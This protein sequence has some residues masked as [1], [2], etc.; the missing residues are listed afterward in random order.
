[1]VDLR[2]E[3]AGVRLRNPTM[4]ASGFLDET[5]GSMARVYEAGAGAVVTKSIGPKPRE[6]YPNPTIVELDA[7]LLNAVGLPNP[8]VIEYEHEVKKAHAAGAVVIGSVFG[9][10]AEEYAAVAAKMSTY[11]V[12]AIELNLSCPHARGLG[13]E[14]AQDASAVRD[15]TRTV[16][17]VVDVPVFPKL[18]PN[19]QDIATFAMAAEEGGADGIVAINTLKAMAI[20]PE[21][22]M[23][24]LANKYGG[25][26]GPAIRSIGVRAVY[27]I[28]E[29]VHVP[30]IGVGGVGSGRD[31]LEYIMA[32]ASAVQIG[33]AILSR[34]LGVF[35]EVVQEMGVLLEEAGFHSVPEAI[36][37]AHA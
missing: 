25:L 10:D 19:V 11:G 15:F 26:S 3:I 28:C 35:D 34:G 6:G 24:S 31:A 21:L 17:D 7:G 4:L 20:T 18:S 32:G 14:I 27:D 23:P 2:T 30:V 36:G 13:T 29:K 37:V 1:M 16:K 12:K 22:K 33:T 8:G 5:G 9:K